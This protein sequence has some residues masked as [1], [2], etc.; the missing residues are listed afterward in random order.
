MAEFA[1]AHG[2][3]VIAT[4]EDAGKSGVTLKGRPALVL[5]LQDVQAL[6]HAF[7]GK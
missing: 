4:Y 5:L 6:T 3:T 7:I 1:A 2:I